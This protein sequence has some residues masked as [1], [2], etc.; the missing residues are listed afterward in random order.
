LSLRSDQPL[1]LSLNNALRVLAHIISL[2][3]TKKA[4]PCYL[5]T[6][7]N[8]NLALGEVMQFQ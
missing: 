6:T 5:D 2:D 4:F 3:G 7:G 1:R 8:K